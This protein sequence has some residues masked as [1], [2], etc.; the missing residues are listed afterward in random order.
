MASPSLPGLGQAPPRLRPA[1]AIALA[2]AF[3]GLAPRPVQAHAIE[4]SLER[5]QSLNRQLQLESRFSTGVPVDGAAVRLV[6][7]G[8]GEGVL[9]GR[10]DGRGQLRFSLPQGVD[11]AW[12]VLVDGGAG[13]RDYLELPVSDHSPAASKAGPEAPLLAAGLL[14]LV[15]S[16]LIRRR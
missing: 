6:P 11:Q 13:H 12:E 8:G 3:C 4:S 14:G 2:L 7:P 9:V 16:N 15:G 1:V 5:L 10:T